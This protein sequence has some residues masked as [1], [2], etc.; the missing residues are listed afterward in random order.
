MV[1]F[2]TMKRSILGLLVATAQFAIAAPK[3][4]VP[5][6]TINLCLVNAG[7]YAAAISYACPSSPNLN[8]LCQAQANVFF[9]ALIIC[10]NAYCT[11]ADTNS[12]VQNGINECAAAGFNVS[13][14]ELTGGPT[15][16]YSISPA[17]S[18]VYNPFGTTSP[19]TDIDTDND[20]GSS[21]S[22]SSGSG[23]SG[24]GTGAIVGIVVG[25]VVVLAIAAGLIIFFV[26]HNAKQKLAM[27]SAAQPAAP[28]PAADTPSAPPVSQFSS[29]APGQGFFPVPPYPAE[30][31]P[32]M[33][34]QYGQQITQYQELE[35]PQNGYFAPDKAVAASSEPTTVSQTPAPIAVQ[36]PAGQFQELPAQNSPVQQVQ[37]GGH[38]Y[39]EMPADSQRR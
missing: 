8:C 30:Q 6:T 19:D 31:Q 10:G 5:D 20:S 37:P 36:P 3:P 12:A 38:V 7:C 34:G 26:K 18:S 27:M 39:A 21:G 28:S 13:E 33:Q 11:T 25:V 14:D 29:P 22:G 35:Q 32:F 16:T 24:L 15:P 1:A 23:S 9:N 2:P 17:T 4:A